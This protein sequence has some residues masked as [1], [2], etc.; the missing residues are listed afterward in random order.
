MPVAQ[1]L[2]TGGWE[3]RCFLCGGE[4]VIWA[5]GAAAG[6]H[7]MRRLKHKL[8]KHRAGWKHIKTC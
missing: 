1:G 6:V 5:R 3:K 4:R 2:E 7:F 8:I